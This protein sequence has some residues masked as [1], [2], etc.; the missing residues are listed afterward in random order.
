MA[1]VYMLGT[2]VLQAVISPDHY[3]DRPGL[4]CCREMFWTESQ[5]GK[6]PVRSW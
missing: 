4:A 6:V 1:V 5:K 3:D 2:D